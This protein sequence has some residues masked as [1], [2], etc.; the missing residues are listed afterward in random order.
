MTTAERPTAS[1]S[2]QMMHFRVSW[3][4]SPECSSKIPMRSATRSRKDSTNVFIAPARDSA[5]SWMVC[6]VPPCSTSALSAWR[7]HW[8]DEPLPP[9]QW[10]ARS[11]R[12]WTGPPRVVMA[13]ICRQ[14][15]WTWSDI[16]WLMSTDRSACA[17]RIC[18]VTISRRCLKALGKSR[19]N[20]RVDAAN[21]ST[22][23]KSPRVG[24]V[25]TPPATTSE[26][27]VLPLGGFARRSSPSSAAAASLPDSARSA[28]RNWAMLSLQLSITDW[29][30]ATTSARCRR[31][32]L[33][34]SF[35]SSSARRSSRSRA[36][37]R[38]S[39]SCWRRRSSASRRARSSSARTS[40][41]SRSC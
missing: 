36:C 20:T 35:R 6:C 3:R 16:T 28:A 23:S 34:R 2:W 1:A 13:L 22:R 15:V 14:T 29:K 25:Y 37:F 30:R 21:V 5:I 9:G 26:C 7:M 11:H 19:S 38:S 12:L 4:G 8:S 10:R 17:S 32:S 18:A 24:D 31:D 27:R 33:A 40:A 39:S 41:S